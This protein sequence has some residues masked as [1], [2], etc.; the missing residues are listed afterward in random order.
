MT[1]KKP[2]RL[3][4]TVLALLVAAPLFTAC[5]NADQAI[6]CGKKAISLTGDVQDLADSA[7][8]VGQITD[9]ER[10]KH[11]VDA[12]KKIIDDAKKIRQDGGSKIGSA[13]DKLS[14][15]V[16]D[17]IDKVSHGNQPDFGAITGAAGDVTKAC[18]DS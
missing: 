12:L 16:N 10:R 7:L 14:K 8:N 9:Q 15:A 4:A 5:K 17:A 11:T 6:D 13:A 3:A 1:R 18:A 2:Y